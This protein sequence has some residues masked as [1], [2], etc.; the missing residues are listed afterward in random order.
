MTNFQVD[1]AQLRETAKAWSTASDDLKSGVTKA[2]ELHDCNKDITWSV[3]QEVWDA[4]VA[5]AQFLHDR[6]SEGSAEAQSI[7][8][9]LNHIATVYQNHDQN[10]AGAISNVGGGN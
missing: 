4:Q 9:V 2:Q 6:L 10:A 7:S 8:N 1:L 5:A 3:F